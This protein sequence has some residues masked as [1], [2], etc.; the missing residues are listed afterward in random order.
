MIYRVLPDV[1]WFTWRVLDVYRKQIMIVIAY[2]CALMC[3]IDQP[4]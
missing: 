1:T 3:Y 4:L 2:L